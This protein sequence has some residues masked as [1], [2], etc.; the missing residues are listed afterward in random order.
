MLGPILFNIYTLPLYQLACENDS[1]SEFYADDSQLYIVCEIES[2]EQSI[3]LLESCVAN[4][5]TW[6]SSNRLKLNG[7]KTELTVFSKPRATCRVRSI[8]PSLHIDNAII[9]PQ[10]SCRVLGSFFDSEMSMETHISNFCKLANFQINSIFSIRQYLDPETLETLVH[11][12]VTSR[13]DYCNALLFG[14]TKR[15]LKRLQRVQNRVAR[16]CLGIRKYDR[17]PNLSLLHKL[18]WL[19]VSYRIE[20]KLLLI[21]YKCL[22]NLA[23]SYLSELISVRCMDRTL[24]SSA[25][26]LLDIPKSMTKTF[27]DRAFSVS[28]PRLWN[29]LPLHLR[30]A[31]SITKFK[32][33]LKTHF[34]N[35][36][37]ANYL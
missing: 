4:F 10:P 26:L 19:P 30:S 31:E 5:M 23:P 11:A 15:N 22:N 34:F 21:T 29:A 3:T 13:M 6:M 16:L 14:I 7:D 17:I 35:I 12:F 24:R 20:F 28:A 9:D 33:E 25:G 37:F 1:L 2:I 8:L 18:H 27:G 32:K 36:A